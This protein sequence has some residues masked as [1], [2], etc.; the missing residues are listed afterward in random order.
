MLESFVI[1]LAPLLYSAFTIP[2]IC[3][4]VERAVH[5]MTVYYFT[6]IVHRLRF[7]FDVGFFSIN[8]SK[9]RNENCLLDQ[10][11]SKRINYLTTFLASYIQVCPCLVKCINSYTQSLC[12]PRSSQKVDYHRSPF[13][14]TFHHS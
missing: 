13:L 5:K 12:M 1:P 9:C 11:K 14:C 7:S 3:Y 4:R 10:K 8:K 6:K 2:G